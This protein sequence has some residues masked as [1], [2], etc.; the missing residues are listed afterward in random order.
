MLSQCEVHIVRGGYAYDPRSLRILAEAMKGDDEEEGG[1]LDAYPRARVV[2]VRDGVH[3]QLADE[4]SDLVIGARLLDVVQRLREHVRAAPY[5]HPERLVGRVRSVDQRSGAVAERQLERGE[6]VDGMPG[7][8]LRQDFVPVGV[9]SG[10]R[11]VR[12]EVVR[13]LAVGFDDVVRRRKVKRV[14]LPHGCD[15]GDALQVELVGVDQ[16]TDQAHLVIGFVADVGQDERAWF[17]FVAGVLALPRRSDACP[18][19][20]SREQGEEYSTGHQVGHRCEQ[21]WCGE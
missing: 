18:N 4:R 8:E 3:A 16:K 17:R 12:V 14:V 5:A 7:V 6:A 21:A 20:K 13:D 2:L 9:H 11:D 15:D 19:S 10:V 1:E